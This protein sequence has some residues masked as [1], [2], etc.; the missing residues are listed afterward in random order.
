LHAKS[1]TFANLAKFEVFSWK[2][3]ITK[4]AKNSTRRLSNGKFARNAAKHSDV[5]FS[6]CQS[7]L[8]SKTHPL[9]IFKYPLTLF[10]SRAEL[11]FRSYFKNFRAERIRYF[12]EKMGD[13]KNLCVVE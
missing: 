3:A 6:Y 13:W 11:L 10:L 1:K 2:T 12:T 4:A 8:S 5:F 9:S 7:Y